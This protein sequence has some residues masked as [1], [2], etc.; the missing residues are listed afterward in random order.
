[1][2]NPAPLGLTVAEAAAIIGVTQQRIDQLMNSGRLVPIIRSTRTLFDPEVVE[3]YAATR[4][5]GQK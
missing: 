4:K 1:V 3:R 2:P 5:R